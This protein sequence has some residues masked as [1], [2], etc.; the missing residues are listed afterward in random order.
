MKKLLSTTALVLALGAPA[1]LSAQTATPAPTSA[2]SSAQTNMNMPGFLAVREES[3]LYASELMGQQVYA[4]RTQ[5]DANTNAGAMATM[6]SADLE[7]MDNIGDINEIILS[8]TGDVRAIV[9][10][11][12]G[13]LGMG[14]Q[15]VAVTMDQVTFAHDADD[16]SQMYIVVNTGADMLK[17]SPAYDRSAAATGT[18]TDGAPAATGTATDTSPV[19]SNDDS[20]TTAGSTDDRT[21]FAAPDMERD[22]YKRVEVTKVSTEMLTG[23]TVYSPDENDVGT[24]TDM[25]VDDSGKITDVIIDFGGFLGLGSSQASLSFNELTVLS[26]DGDEDVR[27]YVNATKEQIQSLPQYEPAN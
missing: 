10:G 5:G 27:V 20:T 6:N 3:D 16:Q 9:I 12:G 25:I 22:G 26:N 15:D 23:K 21:P 7:E 19:A 1:L 14:D 13:F 17:D 24:V 4:R 8:S 18:A 2:T 11:V